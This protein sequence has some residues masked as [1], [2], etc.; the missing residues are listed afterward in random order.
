MR[1][2]T[3]KPKGFLEGYRLDEQALS[4]ADRTTGRPAMVEGANAD[5]EAVLIKTWPRGRG[6]IKTWRRSGP[7]SSAS[8]IDWRAILAPE[9]SCRR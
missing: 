7:T 6:T 1:S 4:P 2:K 8:F 3:R 5:G 9:T